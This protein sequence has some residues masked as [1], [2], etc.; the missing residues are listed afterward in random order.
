MPKN[1]CGKLSQKTLVTGPRR[2]I[3]K[4]KEV[5]ENAHRAAVVNK[6]NNLRTTFRRELE[7]VIASKKTGAS[8]DDVYTT[9]L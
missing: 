8:A 7:K 5:D 1:A 2:M 3:H 4:T 9:R 6:I